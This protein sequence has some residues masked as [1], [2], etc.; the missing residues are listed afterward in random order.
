[1]Y[2]VEGSEVCLVVVEFDDHGGQKVVRCGSMECYE[3]LC[4]GR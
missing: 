2:V 4:E 3:R 1:M